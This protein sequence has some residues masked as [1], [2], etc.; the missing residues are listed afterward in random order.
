MEWTLVSSL[1]L[2]GLWP[3]AVKSRSPQGRKSQHSRPF[4]S[5][6]V[7]LPGPQ[8][9]LL[10]DPYCNLRS[11]A[12]HV[13]F[14][15]LNLYKNKLKKVTNPGSQIV[16]NPFH[17]LTSIMFTLESYCFCDWKIRTFLGYHRWFPWLWW[18]NIL[19]LFFPC[20]FNKLNP[21]VQMVWSLF[22]TLWSPSEYTSFMDL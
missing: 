22:P 2:R 4:D 7:S 21:L 17:S 20:G 15:T 8:V 10:K 11:S 5:K 13:G 18:G 1:Q 19:V 6:L 12:E 14:I 9:G 3:R 16:Q